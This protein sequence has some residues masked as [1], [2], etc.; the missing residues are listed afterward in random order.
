MT[1]TV[2]STRVVTDKL[3]K[4][5][6]ETGVQIA[7]HRTRLTYKLSPVQNSLVLDTGLRSRPWQVATS[8]FHASQE[9]AVRCAYRRDPRFREQAFPDLRVV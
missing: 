2:F 3:G 6:Q 5:E 4:P 7:R 8:E 9:K 1:A